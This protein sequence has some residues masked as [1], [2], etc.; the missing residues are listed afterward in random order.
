M[1]R[2]TLFQVQHTY[3]QIAATV[4]PSAQS[5]RSEGHSCCLPRSR[6]GMLVE[7]KRDRITLVGSLS[8]ENIVFSSG[9]QQ[10]ALSAILCCWDGLCLKGTSA[11]LFLWGQ[12]LMLLDFI[13]HHRYDQLVYFT[14]ISSHPINRDTHISSPHLHHRNK[15]VYILGS[16]CFYYFPKKLVTK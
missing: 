3:I 12:Q 6:L 7:K 8:W 11:R 2:T 5:R 16:R 4:R 13:S 14:I 9:R 15:I 1:T 10:P